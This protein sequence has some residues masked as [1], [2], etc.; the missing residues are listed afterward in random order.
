MDMNDR[1]RS[2]INPLLSSSGISRN[3][4]VPLLGD[5][6]PVV[7]L[8]RRVELN[9]ARRKLDSSATLFLSSSC[10]YILSRSLFLQ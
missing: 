3:L 7:L 9:C 10:L 6:S 1:S 5:A 8:D 4:D 2:R